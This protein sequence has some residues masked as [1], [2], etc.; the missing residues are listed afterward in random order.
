MNKVLHV[1]ELVIGEPFF[2]PGLIG[3]QEDWQFDR[4]F[5]LGADLGVVEGDN[6]ADYGEGNG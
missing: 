5:F 6:A 4:E 2:D 3:V 1:L